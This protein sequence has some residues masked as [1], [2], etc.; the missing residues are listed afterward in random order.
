MAGLVFAFLV[1]VSGCSNGDTGPQQGSAQ[2]AGCPLGEAVTTDGHHRLALIVGVGKYKNAKVPDLAGPPNDAKRLYNLLTGEGGYG[3]PR[4]NVCLLLDEDATTERFKEAFSKG[5]VERADEDDVAVF[6]YAGH[7]SQ[8]RDRNNDE[9][10]ELDET[11]LFHDARTNGVRDLPDDEFNTMLARLHAKT[12]HITVILDSCNSG[13]AMR[14]ADAGTYVARYFEPADSPDEEEGAAL[15]EGAGDGG[16]DWVPEAMAGLVAFTAASDGTPALETGGR[17]IFT[18]AVLKVLSQV[19]GQPLTYAQAARQIP[20]LVAAE[21]YQIPYFHGDLNAPVL[22]NQGRTR[23][24]GWDV[25]SLG[26]P[27]AL[28]GPPLPGMGQGAELRIYD[29]AV[30]GADT[31]DPGKAK[32]TVVI[33]SVSGLN[34]TAHISAARPDAPGPSEGDLALLVRPADAFLRIKVRLRPAE[35]PGGIPAQRAAALR[36]AIARDDEANKLVETTEGAGDFELSVASDGQL[37]LRG[38]ENKIRKHYSEDARVPENLWQHA[39]QRALLRLQGEGGADYTDNQTLRVQ[40]V[41]APKSR[42]TICADGVWEQAEPN[43]EQTIPL[44]HAWNVRVELAQDSPT[45]LLVGGVLLSTDGS[46][47]GLPSDGRKLLLKPGEAVTFNGR[48]ETFAGTP[49]LDVQDHVIVFGTQETNPVP[50]HLLTSTAA[51]RAASRPRSGLYRALDQY[52]SATRGIQVQEEGIED[53]TW[54]LSAMTMRV[55]ANQRFLESQAGSDRPPTQ[56]EYTIK[57]F[58]IRPYL[59]DDPSTALYKVLNK[60]DWL[61]QSSA[62]DGFGYKQHPWDRP[63]DEEN[64]ALGIDCS[65]AIWFAF[66]RAGLPYNRDDRYLTTAMM[67]GENSQM[68]DQF[69]RCDSDPRLQLGDILVYRDETRGDG[70]VVMVID[71]HKRIAWG[72]H[73]WDGTAK[74]LKVKPDTGVEYQLIKYKTDMARWDRQTM[75]RKGCWRYKRFIEEAKSPRGQPGVKSLAEVCNPRRRCGL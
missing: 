45:P 66:T 14:A 35:E 67:V 34:A 1:V 16:E 49:P 42:Q 3:F 8:R 56:R 15:A 23:P 26:P 52:V 48:D 22:G 75:R 21:S 33:D 2:H 30:T 65:R 24:I 70:H 20:P 60:A 36:A 11:F 71:A 18:D 72:S 10:D 25:K 62:E 4:E 59:P 74:E 28:T 13:T 69:E 31:K 47:F 9:P 64:L 53:T 5:L 55:E 6:F 7:G 17:G 41:P 38:P 54:T 40:L 29:G 27:L 37:V 19:G 32:A 50:W 46:T 12:E 73:G 63:T 68:A 51:A 58:D 44:C 43:K 61:A 39:R 57:N